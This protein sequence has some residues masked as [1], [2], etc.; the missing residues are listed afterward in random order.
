MNQYIASHQTEGFF[1]LYRQQSESQSFRDTAKLATVYRL[2]CPSPS[3]M[4]LTTLVQERCFSLLNLT[5]KYLGSQVSWDTDK[6]S[7]VD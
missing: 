3:Q 4:F 1:S 6:K 7:E 2:G 5:S